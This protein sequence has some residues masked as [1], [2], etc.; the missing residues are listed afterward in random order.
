[1]Y[2]KSWSY[3]LFY[4]LN[5]AFLLLVAT[6]CILPLCHVLA[7]SLSSNAAANANLVKFWPVGFNLDSYV[8]TMGSEGFERAFLFSILRTV[9]GT[10]ISMLLCFLAAYS[11]SKDKYTLKGRSIYA[12]YFVITILFNGGLIPTYLVVNATGLRD[13]IWALILPGAVAVFNVVLMMNFFRGIPRELDEAAQ[14]DGS[15]HFRV[16]FSIYLPISM[17]SIATLS[18]FTIVGHW[19]SWFDGMIYMEANNQPLATLIQ[20]LVKNMDFVRLGMNPE[21][22][23]QFSER[24]LRAT[25]I[26]IGALPVLIVYPFLQKYFVGG[27]TVGSVKE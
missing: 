15:T 19:N 3:R 18:L 11:M 20:S 13:T 10:A 7:V 4:Y 14:I 5:M 8:K 9:I 26:F 17:P 22:M 23:K 24:S 25:Q 12:W 1:M 16:L 21:Q 6:I 27:M 2:H